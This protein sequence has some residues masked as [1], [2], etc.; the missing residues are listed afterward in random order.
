MQADPSR[1]IKA[2]DRL[3]SKRS[4]SLAVLTRAQALPS[5]PTITMSLQISPPRCVAVLSC[6]I[7]LN[8]RRSLRRS[9]GSSARV[10]TETIPT[11]KVTSNL[12]AD[13]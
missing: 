11:R 2:P 1:G 5:A 10:A 3:S 9:K 13:P 6:C 7:R 8:S 4:L 12:S